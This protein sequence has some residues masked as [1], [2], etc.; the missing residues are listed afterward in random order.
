MSA[1]QKNLKLKLNKHKLYNGWYLSVAVNMKT[2]ES[3]ID[4]SEERCKSKCVTKK[5][6]KLK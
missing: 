3:V 1:L 5:S 4:R 6:D 2:N